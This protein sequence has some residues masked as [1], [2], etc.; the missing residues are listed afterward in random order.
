MEYLG[1][2]Y[3]DHLQLQDIYTRLETIIFYDIKEHI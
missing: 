3:S 1:V 2:A